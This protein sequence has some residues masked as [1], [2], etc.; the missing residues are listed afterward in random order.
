MKRTWIP[1][2]LFTGLG[3]IT[4]IAL[5]IV[6]VANMVDYEVLSYQVQFLDNDGVTFRVFF[7]ITNPS[8]YDL[9]VWDQHYDIFV[10][11]YKISEVTSTSR[12]KLLKDN[13]SVIP[14]DVHLKWEDIQQKIAPISSQSSITTIGSLPVVIKGKLAAKLGIFKV[15]RLPVRTSMLLSNFLP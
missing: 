7:G 9:E 11:G 2:A 5:S 13:T 6:S 10:A 4:A 3:I 14:L 8:G 15:T 1:V 12:Y